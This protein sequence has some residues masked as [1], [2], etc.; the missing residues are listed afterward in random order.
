MFGRFNITW[1]ARRD[2]LLVPREAI[3]DAETDEAVFIV[4]GGQA[5]RRTITTGYTRGDRVEV[6]EGLSGEEEVVVVGQ[7][8]LKHGARVDV[9]RRRDARIAQDGGTERQAQESK[10]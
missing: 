1:D 6:V 5:E 3:V 4:D 9:V 7:G 10:Q 8:G 2:T